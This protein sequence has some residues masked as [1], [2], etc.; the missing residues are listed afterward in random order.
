M[1]AKYFIVLEQSTDELSVEPAEL[2]IAR[3][4]AGDF[5]LIVLA[6]SDDSQQADRMLTLLKNRSTK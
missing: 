1:T 4:N 3:N 5:P 2:V 6:Q